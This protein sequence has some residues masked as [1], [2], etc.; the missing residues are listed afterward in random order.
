MARRARLLACCAAALL[1]GA[2]ACQPDEF[3]TLL[4]EGRSRYSQGKE[5][6]IIR[7]FF[8]DRRDGFYVDIGCFEPVKISTTYYLERHLGWR[9]IGVDAIESLRPLWQQQRPRSKFISFAV[10]DRSGETLTFHQF[11]GI[12]SLEKSNIETWE[13]IAGQDLPDVEVQVPTITMDDLLA[14]EGV[15][16]I[17][18]LSMDINGTEPAALSA[19]DIRRFRPELVHIEAHQRNRPKLLEYFTRNGYAR[20]DAYLPYDRVNWYFRPAD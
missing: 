3:D 13:K 16:K 1:A 10:T 15:E 17:D 9:G 6:L 7:H 14:R 20:I 8:R 11:G 2:L 19:F 4:E 12:S 18:F 5:E